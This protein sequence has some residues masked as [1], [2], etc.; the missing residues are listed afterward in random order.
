MQTDIITTRR[1]AEYKAHLLSEE[2]S[3]HTVEKYLRDIRAFGLY[4]DGRPLT[5]ELTVSYK[6]HLLESGRYR[7]SSI[8]SMLSSI[9]SFL[10]FI[11]RTDCKAAHIRIQ[12]SPYQPEERNLTKEEYFRLLDAASGNERLEL[13]LK[14]MFST[15]IRVSELQYFTVEALQK[16]VIRVSGKN[17]TRSI[18]LP[19]ELCRQLRAYAK[20]HRIDA[21]VIFRTR[22]GNPVNRSAV[23]AEMKKLCE[24]AGVAPSKVFPHNLRKLYA[25]LFYEISHDIAKLADLLGHSSINTTRIY[26][27]TTESE[28]R[29]HIERFTRTIFSRKKKKATL[30]A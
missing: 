27:M 28:I 13:I 22:N 20:A 25:R 14:T 10:C 7:K 11:G 15:G 24:G 4:L 12:K 9:D 29:E 26:I 21:G 5:K 2:K 19:G 3:P 30:S 8:N 17:K 18:I 23:W 6:T 1:I 16:S